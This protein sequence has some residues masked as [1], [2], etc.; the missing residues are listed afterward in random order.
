MSTLLTSWKEIA[1]H[2]GKSIRTV[3]R[4][5]RESGFPVRRPRNGRRGTV[6]SST[7]E[8]DA[9]L[10]SP[11]AAGDAAVAYKSE[12]ARLR[13]LM[14][15]LRADNQL[16]RQELR[17]I[18]ARMPANTRRDAG[19]NSL[20]GQDLL[21]LCSQLLHNSALLQQNA[22]E[23]LERCQNLRLLLADTAGG[24]EPLVI[25]LLTRVQ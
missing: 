5:E 16:L 22:R 4:W 10:R 6:V 19:I 9:W 20:S 13:K 17:K 2:S 3:Q 14:A 21:A 25:H 8:I 15:A 23:V 11:A 7:E 1:S 24:G 12:N 18:R